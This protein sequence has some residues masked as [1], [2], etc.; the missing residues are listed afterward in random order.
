MNNVI[1]MGR[2]T[3][4]IELREAGNTKVANFSL[5]VDREYK[6]EGQP[7]ADF[8]NCT[9]FGKTA[10]FME[11]YITKGSKI[12]VSGSLQNNN[13]TDREGKSRVQTVVMVNRVEF[14]GA[15]PAGGGDVIADDDEI[16][17]N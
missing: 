16:P 5:A 13:Y 12:L 14:A 10:E 17:F 3:K 6:K 1:L 2:T 9:A 8:F 15:K 4:D 11:K 7:E